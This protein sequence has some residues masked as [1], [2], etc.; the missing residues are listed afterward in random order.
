[1][2]LSPDR[3]PKRN[4]GAIIAFAYTGVAILVIGGAMKY[5]RTL[6]ICTSLLAAPVAG[7][8]GT[9]YY[10]SS[11]NGYY[12]PG[13][14]EPGYYGYYGNYP[15][16]YS[17]DPF[18]YDGFYGFYGGGFGRGFHGYGFG[19]QGFRGGWRGLPR[20]WW[21]PWWWGFPWWRL[22]RRGR[23]SRRRWPS[24]IRFEDDLTTTVSAKDARS[25]AGCM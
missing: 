6:T 21:L 10:G 16:D 19:G 18:L 23:F 20:R 13:Y 9:D 8:V 5:L 12:S 14:Y 4:T 24:L 2:R 11:Y 15:Y 22:S 1:M 7:C 3:A 17:Y 25:G